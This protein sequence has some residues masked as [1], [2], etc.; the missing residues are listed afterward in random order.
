MRF[1]FVCKRHPLIL[2]PGN[3]QWQKD[4]CLF[5]LCCSGV[6]VSSLKK[7]KTTLQVNDNFLMLVYLKMIHSIIIK[8]EVGATQRKSTGFL[9]NYYYWG[10]NCIHEVIPTCSFLS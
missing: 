1:L 4:Y 5:V 7:E 10:C 2:R 9:Q 8:T 3:C 6:L